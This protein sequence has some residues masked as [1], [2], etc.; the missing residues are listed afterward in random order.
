MQDINWEDLRAFVAVAQSG[1][2]G[3]ASRLLRQDPTTIA[4][5]VKRL[6]ERLGITLFERTR[7]GQQ[8][9]EAGETLLTRA[10]AMAAA[11]RDI[12]EQVS[13]PYGLSGTLRI[14]VSE[15]FGSQ[16]LSRYLSRLACQHP[17]LVLD[18]VA[19]SGF[20]S[21]SKREADLSVMLSRPRT[22]PVICQKLADY[23][24]RLYA[25]RDYLAD[26]G[27]IASLAELGKGHTLI[28]YVPDL[29]FAPELNYLEELHPGLTASVRSSSINAQHRLIAERVGV[30][31][32]PCFIGDRDDALQAI[33]MDRSI[34]RTF[35]V[36]THCDTQHLARVKVAK[37]WLIDSVCDGQ[38]E[39]MSRT[40]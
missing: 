18:L 16:F 24:L 1:Q 27:P 21:P 8:L 3:K 36:V 2:L 29:V 6:E 37:Q 39:L 9:T 34:V 13:G 30:G 35:W 4:R 38:T 23:R 17:D 33:C 25:A 15:G 5:K 10:E 22:G 26:R 31:V 14:S 28:G 40:A 19:N 11:A 32:L 7:T 12:G 20:L